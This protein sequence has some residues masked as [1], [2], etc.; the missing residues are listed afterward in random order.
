MKNIKQLITESATAHSKSVAIEDGN[1]TISYEELLAGIERLSYDLSKLSTSEFIG[2]KSDRSIESIIALLSCLVAETPFVF[3][4]E[5]DAEEKNRFKKQILG[6]TK[7]LE[8]S[9]ISDALSNGEE[10]STLTT[11]F[12]FTSVIKAERPAYAIFTSGSTG[13]PK[14]VLVPQDGLAPMTLDHISRLNVRPGSRTLQFARL[15]FDGSISEILWSICSGGTLVIPPQEAISPGEPLQKTLVDHKITHLKTTPFALTATEPNSEMVLEHVI[16]GG[17]ACRPDTVRKWGNI[18]AFHNA[19]GLSETTVCNLMSE[20]LSSRDISGGIPL[21]NQIGLGSITLQNETSESPGITKGELVIEGKC[22]ALGYIS[23]SKFTPFPSTSGVRKCP[24]GDIVE[25]RDGEYYYV[26]RVDRQIKVRGYRIDPG[27]IERIACH[28]PGVKE[29]VF[30]SGSSSNLSEDSTMLFW[31]GEA[32]DRELRAFIQDKVEAYK[33]PGRLM[34]VQA[35]TYTP[36]GKVD[37]TN[38]RSRAEKEMLQSVSITELD[39]SQDLEKAILREISR[40]I[41]MKD[42]TVED[43]FF[44]IGG[45]SLTSLELVRFLRNLGWSSVGV[46]DILIAADIDEI[47]DSADS[48]LKG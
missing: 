21:G 32:E 20:D 46:K 19:Y 47:I 27:E 15:T 14:C 36:N 4:D 26:E 23:G 45:D 30:T 29:A 33:V 44:D 40:L 7:F 39:D 12:D 10:T 34:H 2:I 35:M 42:I 25:Y 11:P 28:F 48:A 13:E 16:N 22:V 5:R 31:S 17:G 18:S 43:N 9:E 1:R 24:T 41:G 6:I 38:L 3:I 37:V 8:S